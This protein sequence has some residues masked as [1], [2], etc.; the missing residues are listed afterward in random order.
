[1]SP[2]VT[3][4]SVVGVADSRAMDWSYTPMRFSSGVLNW[5]QRAAASNSMTLL[6]DPVG[7]RCRDELNWNEAFH[8][9]VTVGRKPAFRAARP[10]TGCDAT[11][12]AYR[13]SPGF[14]SW[15]V[16]ASL[17]GTARPNRRANTAN[18]LAVLLNENDAFTP[19]R[20]GA[21]RAESLTA[22][23]SNSE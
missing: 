18:G 13:S 12:R 2:D 11:W 19:V 8:P 3:G 7:G 6:V 22:E 9:F 20:N 1:M 5:M 21:N 4:T 10:A 16:L 15:S 14:C 23:P 17:G